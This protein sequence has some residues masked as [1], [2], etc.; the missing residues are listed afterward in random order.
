[1]NVKIIVIAVVVLTLLGVFTKIMMTQKE[2]GILRGENKALT[3]EL[4]QVREKS[5]GLAVALTAA[6]KKAKK[7]QREADDCA[8]DYAAACALNET[9][10]SRYS[11]YYK[12]TTGKEL[13]AKELRIN[14]RG[15]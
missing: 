9:L 8:N 4:N 7:L 5:K 6:E 11:A 15:K 10:I 1:M 2:V 12:K 14:R 3:L 13:R